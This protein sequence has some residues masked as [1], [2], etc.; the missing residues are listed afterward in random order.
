MRARHVR[1]VHLPPAG[2]PARLLLAHHERLHAARTKYARGVRPDKPPAA[3]AESL[4]RLR[5][6]YE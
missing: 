5:P 2:D 3:P 6:S 4:P 1:Y